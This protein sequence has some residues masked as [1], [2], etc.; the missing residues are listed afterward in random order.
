[1]VP[2]LPLQT[3]TNATASFSGTAI[4]IYV[5]YN[6]NGS[7]NTYVIVDENSSGNVSAGDTLIILTGLSGSD[8]V[9]SSDF[10]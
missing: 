4:D 10:I 5:Q 6:L 1:M 2:Q 3:I 8:A 7:G 9:D